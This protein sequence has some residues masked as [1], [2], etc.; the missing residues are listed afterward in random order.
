MVS[1]HC[2]LW[3]KRKLRPRL[4]LHLHLPTVHI[5]A[6]DP[7]LGDTPILRAPSKT[8]PGLAE[9][10]LTPMPAW[11]MELDRTIYPQLEPLESLT[12]LSL[13]VLFF[14]LSLGSPFL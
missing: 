11:R 8:L 1:R 14:F 3:N 7:Q 4:A 12:I 9:G 6:P 10:L 5:A 13:E 2:S